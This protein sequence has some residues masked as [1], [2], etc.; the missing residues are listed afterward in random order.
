V[1]PVPGGQRRQINV[2]LSRQLA[3][4]LAAVAF[5]NGRSATEVVRPVVEEFLREQQDDPDVQKALRIRKSRG[6]SV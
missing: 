1:I 3:E 2:S 5:L 6:S 4:V